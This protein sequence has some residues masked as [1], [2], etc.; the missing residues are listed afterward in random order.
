M[1]QCIGKINTPISEIVDGLHI[2]I[3]LTG[4]KVFRIRLFIFKSLI[5]LAAFI[6]GSSITVEVDDD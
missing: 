2:N 6:L 3:K 5:K 1:S 4:V